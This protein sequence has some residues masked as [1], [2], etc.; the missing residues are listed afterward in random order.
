[1]LNSKKDVFKI[2]AGRSKKNENSEPG[3]DQDFR[4]SV[5]MDKYE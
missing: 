1:V 4:N 2:Y 3:S 5:R